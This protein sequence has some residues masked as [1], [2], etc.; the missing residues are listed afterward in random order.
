L[1][2]L[3][4]PLAVP[5]L[6]LVNAQTDPSKYPSQ[7]I[8]IVV[9]FAAGGTLDVA[10]RP[11]SQALLESLGQPV[12]IENKAGANG[13]IGSDLV[14]KANPDGYTLLA[15]TAS[16]A[17]N[18]SMYKDMKYDVLKDFTPITCLMQGVGFIMV[19]HP[20]LPV[21][22]V[23]EFIAY[24]KKSNQSVA[25]SSPGV[26]NTIHIASELFNQRAGTHMLHVP[27]K[28]SAPSLN[29]LVG[30][31]VQVAIMPPGIVMPFIRSGKLRAIG[32]TGE[33]RLAELP[34]VP[35][36]AEVGIKEMVFQGTWMGLF[37]P[38]N[39]PKNI[40]ERLNREFVKV[41]QQPSLRQSL[42]N[43]VAGYVTDGS[44][45]EQMGKIVRDDLKRYAE[46]LQKLN[47][48]PS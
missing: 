3:P 12:L 41:L 14:A 17:L 15:V 10:L 5:W 4:L 33:K 2:I 27:Y 38:A 23:Q 28:G 30:G 7:P 25:Y 16:F 22:T 45:P 48:Q 8:K 18:P 46:I 26:G 35:T 13:M 36:M 29:A 1:R 34:D 42:S 21:K 44:T 24:E 37:G 6:K 32:F 43:S 9:P 39:M 20:S 31:E 19:V 47:I 11:I 40:V